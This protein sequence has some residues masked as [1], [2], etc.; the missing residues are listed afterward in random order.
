MSSTVASTPA[1]VLRDYFHAKDENRPH[2][3]A[4]V[5]AVD[6]ELRVDNAAANIA[7]PAVTRGR[8]AIAEVLVRSFAQTYE[9]IYTYYLARPPLEATQFSCAWLVGM[10]EKA[11]GNV[12]VGCGRYDWTFAAAPPHLA[13]HL[14]I[15][16]ETMQVLPAEHAEA[17][18]AW[19]GRLRYPWTSASAVTKSAPRIDLLAPVLQRLG[20]RIRAARAPR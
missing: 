9:N 18:F 7:F 14:T 5:F 11:N 10:S 8:D 2:V 19:L 1:T 20:G 12:R 3:L 4:K 13:T 16:I 17:V 15:T 6:A